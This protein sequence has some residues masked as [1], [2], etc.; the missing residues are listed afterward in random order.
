MHNI[1]A[2]HSTISQQLKAEFVG[3]IACTI[4]QAPLI[5]WQQ[6]SVYWALFTISAWQI[7]GL[8][9]GHQAY[10]LCTTVARDISSSLKKFL[11]ALLPRC[12]IL[13]TPAEC[14]LYSN[15]MFQMP[16]STRGV[17]IHLL[18]MPG[19]S[20]AMQHSVA[21]VAYFNLELYAT[22]SWHHFRYRLNINIECT[23][24]D[25]ENLFSF[26]FY[27]S[28]HFFFGGHTS[29]SRDRNNNDSRSSQ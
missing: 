7:K 19:Q 25:W 9:S 26:H 29:L 21:I 4:C 18:C 15:F 23:D 13:C 11:A 27:F 22:Y 1:Y 28:F 16:G 10:L 17:S 12:C 5:C 2:V 14:N 8:G 20:C 6:F 3:F 24:I